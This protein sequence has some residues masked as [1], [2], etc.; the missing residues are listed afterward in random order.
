MACHDDGMINIILVIIIIT[1]IRVQCLIQTL[2]F[3]FSVYEPS[4]STFS[5]HRLYALTITQTVSS[6]QLG[7]VV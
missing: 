7:F 4:L 2:S 3:T 5:N 1:S 6:K